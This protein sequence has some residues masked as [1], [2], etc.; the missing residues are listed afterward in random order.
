MFDSIAPTYD[1]LNR[2]ISFGMDVGWRRRAV[3]AC[4]QGDPKVVLDVGA[5]TGDL[6]LMVAKQPQR[7]R[8]T[9]GLDFSLPMLRRAAQRAARSRAAVHFALGDALQIPVATGAIDAIVTA[10]TLRN[11]ADLPA[12]LRSFARVLAP[13]GTLVILEMTPLGSGLLARLFRLYFHRVVPVIGKLVSGHRY[14]YTYLP[15]SVD[16]FPDAQAFANMIAEC[17]FQVKAVHKLGF[18]SVAIHSAI[19]SVDAVTS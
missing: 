17:G 3:S 14:A 7:P 6:T 8:Q 12:A 16:V 10:F 9:V 11:V 2:F 1:L 18:G 4:M 13:G 5:G 19:R 15:R